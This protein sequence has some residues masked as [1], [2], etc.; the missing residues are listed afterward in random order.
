MN[1]AQ[2]WLNI[3]T[4]IRDSAEVPSQE[5]WLGT[6]AHV[7]RACNHGQLTVRQRHYHTGTS[8]PRSIEVRSYGYPNSA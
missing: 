3:P 7:H 1:N 4:H 8:V 5:A 2:E 6:L